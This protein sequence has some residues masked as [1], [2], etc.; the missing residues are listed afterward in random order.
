MKKTKKKLSLGKETLKQVTGA[1]FTLPGTMIGCTFGCPVQ[2]AL[3]PTNLQGCT[4]T[5]LYK[6]T[7][8]PYAC[9]SAIVTCAC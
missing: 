1:G 8:G 2:S 6:W 3:C 7:C 4:I 9:D 5:C